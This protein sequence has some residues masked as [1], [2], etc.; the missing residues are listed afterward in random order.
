[1][2]QAAI[3][4]RT[5]LHLIH[6]RQ[7]LAATLKGVTKMNTYKFAEYPSNSSVA[8]G[9]T[10]LVSVWFLVAAG[11][12]LADPH[13]V[14]TERVVPQATVAQVAAPAPERAVAQAPAR[15]RYLQVSAHQ[16]AISPEARLTIT[17]EAK[18]T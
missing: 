18:R 1:M 13:S 12:I 5:H 6:R 11:A 16:S 4:P 2:F 14:Y 8:S 15:A 9:V 3:K 7:E 10:M 17:V